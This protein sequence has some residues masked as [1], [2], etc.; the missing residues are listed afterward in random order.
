MHGSAQ[1]RC[2]RPVHPCYMSEQTAERCHAKP[3]GGGGSESQRFAV[4]RDGAESSS[5]RARKTLAGRRG[6][7]LAPRRV[8]GGA[9]WARW[10][11]ESGYERLIRMRVTRGAGRM[12]RDVSQQY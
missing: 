5:G 2:G 7:G 11:V 12:A 1:C 8:S 4:A 10:K 3:G 6:A 9:W